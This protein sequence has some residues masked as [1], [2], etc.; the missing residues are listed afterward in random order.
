MSRDAFRILSA[1]CCIVGIVML[2]AS[3]WINPG[4]PPNPTSTQLAA[5][6]QQYFAAILWGAW[7]QAVGTVLTVVFA[8]AIVYLAG[9]TGRFAGVIAL[10]GGAILTMAGLVEVTFYIVTLSPEPPTMG[11]IGLA[12]INATQHVYLIVAAP[13]L[14][15]PLGA[16]I[17]GSTVLPRIFGFLTLPLGVAF[18]LVGAL[19]LFSPALPTAVT[20]FRGA[21]TVWCLAAAIA[22]VV[23]PEEEVAWRP[24]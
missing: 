18:A 9:A 5:F 21:Q 3:F 2:G 14:F 1:V 11:L 23:R 24:A 12:L 19:S 20:A 16:V 22:L 15:L 7:L 6:A 10:F 4:P 13:S 8:F 17:L